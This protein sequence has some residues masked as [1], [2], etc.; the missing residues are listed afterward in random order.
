MA[1]IALKACCHCNACVAN[2]L[3]E[4]CANGANCKT[5]ATWTVDI[6]GLNISNDLCCTVFCGGAGGSRYRMTAPTTGISGTFTLTQHGTNR[7]LWFYQSVADFFTIRGIAGGCPGTESATV[8]AKLTITLERIS[9]TQYTMVVYSNPG[10]GFG[11]PLGPFFSATLTVVNES[12]CC[13]EL[14][15]NNDFTANCCYCTDTCVGS[16]GFLGTIVA[17]PCAA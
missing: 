2:H 1:T 8:T 14:T 5:P 15:F 6:T 16:V 3:C 7:C 11:I 12:D 17:R 13:T 4:Y 10:L 9:D